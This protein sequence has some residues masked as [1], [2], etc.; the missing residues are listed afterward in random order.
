MSEDAMIA[1][2]R[3]RKF[4]TTLQKTV[5]CHHL[6]C[7]HWL[8]VHAILLLDL[9]A[10]ENSPVPQ[11]TTVENS[12]IVFLFVPFLFVLRSLSNGSLFEFSSPG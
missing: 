8:A 10:R 4:V 11:E 6:L 12:Y 3:K 2:F 7:H 1:G 5:T 9:E